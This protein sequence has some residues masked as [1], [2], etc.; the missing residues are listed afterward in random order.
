MRC[1]D[2]GGTAFKAATV[3]H[4]MTISGRTLR[5]EL[6]ARKCTACGDATVHAR[7]LGAW[8]G[9]VVQYLAAHGPAT[10]E[11]LSFMRRA[12]GLKAQEFAELIGVTP[13][14]VSRWEH[15]KKPLDRITWLAVGDLLTDRERT[16][17]RLKALARKQ[18]R[19]VKLTV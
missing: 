9:A 8:E 6:P 12:N 2:C 16:V 14:T 5:G 7:D 3:P 18:R 19:S 4:A 11:A 15:A 1:L 13:T 10:G 17:A